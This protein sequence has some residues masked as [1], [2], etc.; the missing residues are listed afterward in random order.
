MSKQLSHVV[1]FDDAPFARSHRGD[2]LVAGAVFAGARLDG[3]LSTRVRRDGANATGRLAACI[4]A[5]K[6][7][8]QLHAVLLQ[9][10]AFAGFNVVDLER[11]HRDTGL[12]VLVVA[13]RKPSLAAIRRAL[14]DHVPGGKRKW[15]LIEAAGPMEP[16]AGVFVQR[17]GIGETQARRLIENLQINGLMPEPLRVAH[18][19]AGGVT[20]GKSRHRA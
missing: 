17:Q 20:T 1:G 2:V 7:H 11:L 15:R 5:S 3:V 8:A 10:I 16:L 19:I 14:L 9:G 6:F 18:M 4:T 13:R 12:P